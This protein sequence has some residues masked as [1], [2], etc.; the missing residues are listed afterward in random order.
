MPE[1]RMEALI[2]GVGC[3]RCRALARMTREVLAELGAA[4]VPLTTLESPEDFAGIDP[5]LPPALVLG[6]TVLVS[7]RVP[8]Q[9]YLRRL[10]RERLEQKT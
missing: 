9:R 3:R 2:I 10:I 6:G 1:T 4:D 5:I 7:G 8:S